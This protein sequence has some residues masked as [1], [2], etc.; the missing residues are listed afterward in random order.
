MRTFAD[1]TD[2]TASGDT[3]ETV[4]GTITL[5]SRAKRIVGVWCSMIG[6]AALTHSEAISGII[7]LDSPDFTLAPFKFPTPQVDSITSGMAAYEPRII[8]VSIPCVGS[9]RV[10]AY[11]T[12]DMA[13]TGAHKTRVGVIYE[14]DE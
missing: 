3:T 7:R 2:A 9:G 10:T 5:S 13:L 6:G 8:P 1:C 12:N 11:V 4:V 14:G